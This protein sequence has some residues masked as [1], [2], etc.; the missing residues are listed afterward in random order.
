MKK[1]NNSIIEIIA[2]LEKFQREISVR[3]PSA[4]SYPHF[5][6]SG[7]ALLQNPYDTILSLL[8]EVRDGK[9]VRSLNLR[10]AKVIYGSLPRTTMAYDMDHDRELK[11]KNVFGLKES[12]TFL[13]MIL[14]LPHLREMCVT[15]LYLLPVTTPS[16]F[17]MK[18]GAPCPYSVKD[19]FNLDPGLYD[20]MTGP[21]SVESLELQFGAL[22]AA[23]EV[24]GIKVVLD[25][26]PRS[27]G[28]DNV[29]ILEHPEWFYWIR[30]EEEKN[31]G[32]PHVDG[33]GSTPFSPEHVK[34]I[35]S[36]KA[37]KK[38]I[39]KFSF[40]PD[41]LFPERW[42]KFVK[43]ILALGGSDILPKIKKEFGI[44]TAPAFS[45]VINDPQPAWQDVTFFAP[46]F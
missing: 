19:F 7:K 34:K 38:H 15:H 27:A 42:K 8:K 46:P 3:L 21:F 23:A 10:P 17:V 25:F 22:V 30:A 12:G 44:T 45:D 5:D 9:I 6:H 20:P 1:S 24:F 2:L 37:V 18:G 29:L 31:Y 36:S 14:L 41:I 13:R 33:L 39:A 43:K 32:P 35:Y 26:I 28:R 40:S 16:T 11:E 4:W